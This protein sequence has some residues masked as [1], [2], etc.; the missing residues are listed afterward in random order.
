MLQ[1]ISTI[2][3]CLKREIE[4]GERANLRRSKSGKRTKMKPTIL[5]TSNIPSYLRRPGRSARA[6]HKRVQHGAVATPGLDVGRSDMGD[7]IV[8]W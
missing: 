8:L 4:S 3:L 5:C 2:K 7:P 6:A 1:W